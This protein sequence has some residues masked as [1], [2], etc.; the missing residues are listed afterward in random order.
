MKHDLPAH[1][2]AQAD[3]F[4]EV[5]E[6]LGV[7]FRSVQT[8]AHLLDIIGTQDAL[9]L[10]LRVRVEV[11]D[12]GHLRVGVLDEVLQRLAKRVLRIAPADIVLLAARKVAGVCQ[13]LLEAHHDAT[14][15]GPVVVTA[16]AENAL[17][18][19]WQRTGVLGL[20][21]RLGLQIRPQLTSQALVVGQ[22]DQHT[23]VGRCGVHYAARVIAVFDVAVPQRAHNRNLEAA[24]E[25]VAHWMVVTES[26]EAEIA[27]GRA[28]GVLAHIAQDVLEQQLAQFTLFGAGRNRHVLD[29]A[30]DVA[31]FVGEKQVEVAVARDERLALEPRERLLDQQP[32]GQLVG[33]DLIHTQGHQVVH[34]AGEF[35]DVSDEKEH[36]QHRGVERLQGVVVARLVDGEL[37]RGVEK[38]LHCWI[39]EMKR[40]QRTDLVLTELLGRALKR[41]E[42]GAFTPREMQTGG[43]GLADR[44]EH[45]LH[46]RELVGGEGVA[47]REVVGIR[48]GLERHTRMHKR[49][50]ILQ[51]VVLPL[52]G[53]SQRSRSAG[54][55][56]QEALLDDLIDVGAREREPRLEATLDLREVLPL[57]TL[58]IA[59]HG[60]E[61][62]L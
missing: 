6:C 59:K 18:R 16:I 15:A 5:G 49:E 55:L 2:R 42:G 38:P 43:A 51:D 40:G 44:L 57:G 31:L 27:A 61:I 53:R 54:V 60:V 35:V 29:L 10:L 17:G 62:L 58:E 37:D 30:P 7:G 47:S 4:A 52:V 26:G 56:L 46:Q 28:V 33:V 34:A 14:S 48:V 36:L 20:H 9:D 50:L 24:V 3:V 13:R 41:V 23:A 45:L 25:L 19:I 11:L 21:I 1:C 39:K 8:Q 22:P 32:Q 12:E